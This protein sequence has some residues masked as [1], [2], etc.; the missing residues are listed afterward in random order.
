MQL[1]F[2]LEV[3]REVHTKINKSLLNFGGEKQYISEIL[4]K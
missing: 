2:M 4:Q 1:T 3:V